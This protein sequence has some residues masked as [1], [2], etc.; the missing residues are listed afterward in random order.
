MSVLFYF[1][2]LNKKAESEGD[3]NTVDISPEEEVLFILFFVTNL[4][5]F[6][7]EFQNILSMTESK[8]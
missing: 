3:E 2:Q 4:Q 8:K 1:F 5:S 6:W 7:Y